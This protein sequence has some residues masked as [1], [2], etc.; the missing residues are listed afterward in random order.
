[1]DNFITWYWVVGVSVIVIGSLASILISILIK[2]LNNN[3]KANKELTNNIY[4]L[5]TKL[6]IE[7]LERKHVTGDVDDLKKKVCDH[8]SRITIIEIKNK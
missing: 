5:G 1:M 6:E 8:E 3:I 2:S 7:K 4:D